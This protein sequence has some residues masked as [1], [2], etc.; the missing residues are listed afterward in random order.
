MVTGPQAPHRDD[1]TEVH[2][3]S[4]RTSSRIA[5]TLI[6]NESDFVIRYFRL[7]SDSLNAAGAYFSIIFDDRF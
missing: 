3:D 6:S 4:S 2:M 1:T 5:T 7:P